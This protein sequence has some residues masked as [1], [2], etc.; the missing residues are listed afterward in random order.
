[1]DRCE[2]GA[3][4][5][6]GARNPFTPAG[7]GVQPHAGEGPVRAQLD[8]AFPLETPSATRRGC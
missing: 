2:L 8:G 1:M 4:L 6:R 7:I 3:G 5:L